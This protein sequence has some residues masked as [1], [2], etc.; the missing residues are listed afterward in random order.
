MTQPINPSPDPAVSAMTGAAALPRRNGELVFAE[1]WEGRAF[2][3]AVALNESGAY[4]WSDFSERLIEETAADERQGI[5]VNYYQRWLR[6]LERL[7]LDH[8]LLTP[9]ELEARTMTLA[10]EDPNSSHH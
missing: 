8:S 2:G 7:A 5:H 1:P 3:L 9:A 6:A 4:D 10:T